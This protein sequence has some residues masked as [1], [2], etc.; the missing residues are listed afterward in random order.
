VMGWE[1]L[2]YLELN[3]LGEFLGVMQRLTDWLL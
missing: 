2:W 3:H 1:R